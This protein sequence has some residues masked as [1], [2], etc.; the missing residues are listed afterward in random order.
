MPVYSL[1][2][3]VRRRGEPPQWKAFLCETSAPLR[4]CGEGLQVSEIE[5]LIEDYETS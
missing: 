3:E 2:A 1:T 4:L 5:L